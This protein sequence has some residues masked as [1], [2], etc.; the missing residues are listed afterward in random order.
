MRAAVLTVIGL[1]RL[2]VV[3]PAARPEW[4][5]ADQHAQEDVL[6]LQGVTGSMLIFTS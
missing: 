1:V 6:D 2:K 5:A 3:R 4:S